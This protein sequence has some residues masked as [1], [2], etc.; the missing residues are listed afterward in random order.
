MKSSNNILSP[1][2]SMSE[3]DIVVDDAAIDDFLDQHE[4]P[5]CSNCPI[6][7]EQLDNY[8]A[9]IKVLKST[10]SFDRYDNFDRCDTGLSEV[11]GVS[12]SGSNV[13]SPDVFLRQPTQEYHAKVVKKEESDE[14]KSVGQ[15][16]VD[17]TDEISE[18]FTGPHVIPDNPHIPAF[19]DHSHNIIDAVT[20]EVLEQPDVSLKEN[21]PNMTEMVHMIDGR[22]EDTVAECNDNIEIDVGNKEMASLLED[23]TQVDEG[24]E[25]G[26]EEVEGVV[27]V[28]E[29]EEGGVEEEPQYVQ[30]QPVESVGDEVKKE[31]ESGVHITST[32]NL[33]SVTSD[34]VANEENLTDYALV[35]GKQEKEGDDDIA[36][37]VIQEKMSNLPSESMEVTQYN[38]HDSVESG[39]I[40]NVNVEAKQDVVQLKDGDDDVSVVSHNTVTS[41]IADINGSMRSIERVESEELFSLEMSVMEEDSP[42][43]N[44]QKPRKKSV[45]KLVKHQKQKQHNHLHSNINSHQKSKS[46]ATYSDNDKQLHHQNFRPTPVEVSTHDDTRT[47]LSARMSSILHSPSS[48]IDYRE[49]ASIIE[50]NT[51]SF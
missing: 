25:E 33:D 20:Q 45:S 43:H 17:K 21:M 4:P 12:R 18:N 48:F 1:Q 35:E 16:S 36:I 28:I 3:T 26:E 42:K 49:H 24:K 2:V 41:I 5:P 32:N 37:E 27:G 50:Q 39:N 14:N 11:S 31:D 10:D 38:T 30:I 8:K 7:Q 46:E 40:N 34:V 13:E 29:E 9:K 15:Q 6:L 44:T 19:D 47:Q 23:D 22:D 51:V